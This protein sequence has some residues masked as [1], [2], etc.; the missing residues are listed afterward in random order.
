MI[1]ISLLQR[2]KLRHREVSDAI[3]VIQLGSQAQDLNLGSP[4]L[5][6]EFSYLKKQ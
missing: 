2:R 1:I 5:E 4:A 6:S 3:K